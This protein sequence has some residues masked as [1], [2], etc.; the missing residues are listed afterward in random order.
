M[1]IEP[2]DT[3]SIMINLLAP[4]V[5]SSCSWSKWCCPAWSHNH[6]RGSSSTARTRQS[7]DTGHPSRRPCREWSRSRSS[8]SPGRSHGP[9]YPAQPD[10]PAATASRQSP[11]YS[12]DHRDLPESGY[13]RPAGSSADCWAG[14]KIPV[15]G[16][17]CCSPGCPSIGGF[18]RRPRRCFAPTEKST[19]SHIQ[20]SSIKR[21]L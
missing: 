5:P 7:S 1:F 11:G 18:C 13:R 12:T 15:W 17:K 14:R 8:S 19:V 16:R 6:P 4:I 2:H 21:W 10:T 3:S 9:A 20:I